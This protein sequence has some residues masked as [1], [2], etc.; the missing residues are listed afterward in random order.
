M[1]GYTGMVHSDYMMSTILSSQG[2]PLDRYYPLDISET[3]LDGDGIDD[4]EEVND[5][6]SNTSGGTYIYYA[7]GQ[8][9]VGSNNI[10]NT[11]H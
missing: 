4:H 2:E 8:T 3:D 9:L 10:P 1:I 5:G 6:D 11:V 7:V